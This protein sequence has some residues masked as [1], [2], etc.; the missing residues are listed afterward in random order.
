MEDKQV[1]I[2]DDEPRYMSCNCSLCGAPTTRDPIYGDLCAR[3]C[4][5]ENE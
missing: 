1:E 3:C 2:E 4:R 5:V